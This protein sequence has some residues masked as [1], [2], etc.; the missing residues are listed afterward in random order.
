[1]SQS[2]DKSENSHDEK[3]GVNDMTGAQLVNKPEGYF[4]ATVEE[5]HMNR[6]VN[7]KLDI[8][9]LP[10]LSMLYLFSGLDRGTRSDEPH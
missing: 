10:F 9:I 5:K 3:I 2:L 6:K 7:R 8:W 1:M 4:P